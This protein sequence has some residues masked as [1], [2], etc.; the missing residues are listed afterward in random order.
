MSGT[1]LGFIQ[2]M[3]GVQTMGLMA[4]TLNPAA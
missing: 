4:Q 1:T 2:G 3:L